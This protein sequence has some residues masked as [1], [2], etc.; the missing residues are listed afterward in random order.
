VTT[1]RT[2]LEEYLRVRRAL[3]FALKQHGHSL[4]QF[5]EYAEAHGVVTITRRLAVEWATRNGATPHEEAWRRLG[6]VRCFAR[7]WKVSDPRTEVPEEGL[8]PR[9]RV[10]R[11]PHIFTKREMSDLL[12]CCGD[13]HS[14]FSLSAPTMKTFLGLLWSTGMRHGEALHLARSDVD[15]RT[16]ILRVRETKFCKSR[17]VPVHPST[18]AALAAYARMRDRVVRRQP[19]S[20][21]FFAKD[22]GEPYPGCVTRD[23]FIRICAL[24]GLRERRARR[25]VRIHD[26]RHTFAI[27]TLIRW[28][29][30][31]ADVEAKMLFLATY[32]G[33]GRISDTYWYLSAVPE[34][35][36]LAAGRL[37]G[38]QP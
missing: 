35:V 23:L 21:P 36:T 30:E 25:G 34:L 11:I 31:G 38:W 17:F 9:L 16:G 6:W 20:A 10:K 33:H 8:L 24:A 3:G 7:F 14:L 18:R 15:L 2:G 27:R 26:L 32:L 19:D 1:L 13:V 37:E 12:R 22:N 28:Y 29:R 5:V 4:G